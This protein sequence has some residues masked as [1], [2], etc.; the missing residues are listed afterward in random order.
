[1]AITAL[2]ILLASSSFF[3]EGETEAERL[4]KLS[5]YFSPR[6]GE[7]VSIIETPIPKKYLTELPAKMRGYI[8]VNPPKG[9][10]FTINRGPSS[11]DAIVCKQTNVSF[12]LEDSTKEGVLKWIVYVDDNLIQTFLDWRAPYRIAYVIPITKPE[13]AIPE[14]RYIKSCTASVDDTG[15]R[16]IKLALLDGPVWYFR[17]PE[18]DILLPQPPKNRN[19]LV[20]AT[21]KISVTEAAEANRQKSQ[22]KSGDPSSQENLEIK[23]RP[24]R[25]PIDFI[26]D[27]KIWHIPMKDGYIMSSGNFMPRGD[28][29]PGMKGE[30]RYRFTGSY[31]DLD[32]GRIE[33]KNADLYQFMYAPLT[34]LKDLGDPKI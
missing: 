15:T 30:C 17:F 27:R 32:V 24:K 28:V 11:Q 8:E 3:V 19:V 2:S 21:D 10:C 6:I 31:D 23:A 20:S 29:T 14:Y 22:T 5:P 25:I 34:C 9:H 12:T 16:N 4:K 7:K 1:M 13:N 26:A 33:C 18:K